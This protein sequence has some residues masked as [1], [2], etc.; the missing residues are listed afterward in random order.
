[1]SFEAAININDMWALYAVHLLHN[2]LRN[3]GKIVVGSIVTLLGVSYRGDV[4]DT[5]YSGSELIMRKISEMGGDIRCTTR[6]LIS[7]GNSRARIL[8]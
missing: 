2:V 6:T 8:I 3:T 5:S 1:M 7:G 4:G